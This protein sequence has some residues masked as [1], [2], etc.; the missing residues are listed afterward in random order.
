MLVLIGAAAAFRAT[1]LPHMTKPSVASKLAEANHPIARPPQWLPVL[2]ASASENPNTIEGYVP[3]PGCTPRYEVANK[4]DQSQYQ[5]AAAWAPIQVTFNGATFG[6]LANADFNSTTSC[7]QM[8]AFGLNAT[9]GTEVRATSSLIPGG[10]ALGWFGVEGEEIE[11][12]FWNGA[13]EKEYFVHQKFTMGASGSAENEQ[14]S[15]DIGIGPKILELAEV[16]ACGCQVGCT[17]INLSNI[18]LP[19][20]EGQFCVENEG[21]CEITLGTDIFYQCQAGVDTSPSV[22]CYT[23]CAWPPPST[24]P[25]PPPPSPSPPPPSPPPPSPSPPPPSPPPPSPSPPPPSPSPP[26]PS[27]P[28]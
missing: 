23:P 20:N 4:T 3:N 27:P 24:P 22:S 7:D 17:H 6:F 11:F 9:N 25:S 12:R 1:F 5:E 2:L 18:G 19:L 26:P 16:P 14:G 10:Y 13:E 21:R 28:P 8:A 15:Y